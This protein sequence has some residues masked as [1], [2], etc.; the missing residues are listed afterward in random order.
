MSGQVKRSHSLRQLLKSGLSKS[1]QWKKETWWLDVGVEDAVK[2]KRARF[3]A[4]RKLVKAGLTGEAK[5]AKEAYNEAERLAKR[6]VWQV[7][8]KAKEDT[9]ANISPN[10]SS[11]FKVAKQMDMTN[12]CEVCPEVCP[13]VC[14]E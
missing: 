5:A 14:Q 6:A 11:I 4:Y 3:K 2:L 8:A 10:D 13:E 12:Q 9:F 7:R 1:H